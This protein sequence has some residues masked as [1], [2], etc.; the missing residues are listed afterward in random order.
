ML[1]ASSTAAVS[2]FVA[3][4]ATLLVLEVKAIL[5][6]VPAVTEKVEVPLVKPAL[7]AVIVTEPAV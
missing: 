3:P 4:E 1:F 7:E 2:V 5:V 6:A